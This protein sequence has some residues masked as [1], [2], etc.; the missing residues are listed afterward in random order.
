MSEY[1]GFNAEFGFDQEECLK[2]LEKYF[3][4]HILHGE[5]LDRLVRTIERASSDYALMGRAE[6]FDIDLAPATDE[7]MYRTERMDSSK[8]NVTIDFIPYDRYEENSIFWRK[9]NMVHQ[10]MVQLVLGVGAMMAAFDIN[11]LPKPDNFVAIP[12][13]TMAGFAQEYLGFLPVPGL[14]RASSR[15]AYAATFDDAHTSAEHFLTSSGLVEKSFDRAL[16]QFEKRGL[17]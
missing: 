16:L 17:L 10:S 6:F 13:P 2:A 9:K 8:K 1:A 7:E 11:A 14:A 5:I 15:L 4:A 12:N 3:P